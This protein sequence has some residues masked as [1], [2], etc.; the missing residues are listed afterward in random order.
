ML[1]YTLYSMNCPLQLDPNSGRVIL[2]V[3]HTPKEV[4]DLNVEPWYEGLYSVSKECGLMVYPMCTN[5]YM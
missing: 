4:C 2:S 5:N 1:I 3:I